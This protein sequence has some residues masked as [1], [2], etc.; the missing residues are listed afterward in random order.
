MSKIYEIGIILI[1]ISGLFTGCNGVSKVEELERSNQVLQVE[2]ERLEEE[3]SILE[4]KLT[5]L[6][7]KEGNLKSQLEE[8]EKTLERYKEEIEV[9]KK[10]KDKDTEIIDKN[11]I[12]NE[13]QKTRVYVEEYGSMPPS[14]NAPNTLFFKGIGEGE[15]LELKVEGKITNLR[16]VRV[17]FSENE[18]GEFNFLDK[19]VIIHADKVENQTVIIETVFPCGIPSANVRWDDEEGGGNLV[20]AYDGK[21]GMD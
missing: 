10:D 4:Q 7:N 19:E 5:D 8:M 16:S 21:D 18:V 13:D 3:N 1:L 12:K 11:N 17:E 2:K 15:Y 14:R 20:L 6:E 9:Q